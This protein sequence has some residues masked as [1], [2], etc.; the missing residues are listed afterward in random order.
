[1]RS[2]RIWFA[3]FGIGVAAAALFFVFVR[4][5]PVG[6]AGDV[7]SPTQSGSAAAVK[8]SANS[9]RDGKAARPARFLETATREEWIAALQQRLADGAT[10]EEILAD[11]KF[12]LQRQPALAVDLALNVARSADEKHA[13][14]GALLTDWT[15]FN[16]DA[17]WAK[18]LELTRTNAVSGDPALPAL[19]L[20]QLAKFDPDRV[21]IFADNVLQAGQSEETVGFGPAEVTHAAIRALLNAQQSELARRT[22]ERWSGPATAEALGNGAYEEAALEYA[23]RSRTEAADWLHNLPPSSGRDFALATLAADWAT[24]APQDAMTWA[25]SLESPSARSE[26]MQRAFNRWADSDIV[27]AAQW[28]ADHDSS[29]QADTLIAN[30]VGDT[31]L[32]HVAPERAIQWSE[33]IRDPDI[34]QTAVQRVVSAWSQHDAVAAARFTQQ[35]QLLSPAMRQ[36]LLDQIRRGSKPAE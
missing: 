23:K 6:P 19:V 17:A 28:V 31:S 35:T 2:G 27:A 32:G 20:G 36:Q 26:A 25:S 4:R 12:L 16:P 10:T 1:M 30:L 21:V 3:L 8:S 14:V 9:G 7:A 34:R 24:T 33:L 13:W 29:P 15:A 22:V 11:L 18:S 5:A